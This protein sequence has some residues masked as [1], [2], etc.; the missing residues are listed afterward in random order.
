MERIDTLTVKTQ[1]IFI[2]LSNYVFYITGEVK[3][4]LKIR[5]DSREKEEFYIKK[6]VFPMTV[7]LLKPVSALWRLVSL[8]ILYYGL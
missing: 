4:G 3:L 6:L 1:E 5:Y 8:G 2:F 7:G